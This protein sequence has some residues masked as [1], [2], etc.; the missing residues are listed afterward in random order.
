VETFFDPEATYIWGLAFDGS[1]HLL[2]ATGQPARVHRVAA[3]GSGE[4]LLDSREAHIR[5]LVPDG[6]GGF[7]AGSDG[8]GVI[9]RIAE[10]GEISVLYDTP[11]REISALAV[12]DGH[13]YAAALAPRTKRQQ[14]T[15]S[16]DTRGTVTHVRVTAEGG[17]DQEDEGE[18]QQKGQG[19]R[20]RR[21]PPLET[22]TGAVYRI[23][24]QGYARKIWESTDS[25]P[26]A[27]LPGPG[28]GVLAGTAGGGKILS[29]TPQGDASEIASLESEQV[30]ALLDAGGSGIFAATSNLGAVVR[31]SGSYAREG[32]ILGGVRDAGFT[33]RWGAITWNA[34]VPVGT[35]V[36]FEVRTG[37]TE[38]P[39]S[40]WTDWSGPYREPQ[41]TVIESPPARFLQ[42]RATLTSRDGDVSPVVKAVQIHYLPENMPPEVETVEILDP[43]VWLQSTG[44]PRGGGGN[45]EAR[46]RRSSSPKRALQRGMRTVQWTASDAN[47]DLLTAE[48]RFRA[49]DE[50]VW[51]ILGEDLEESFFAWDSTAMP[52]GVYRLRVVISDAPGNPSGQG[53]STSRD[54]AAFEVDNTPPVVA[55]IVAKRGSRSVVVTATV[56][57]TFSGVGEISYSLDAGDWVIVMP[58][59]GVAD[60]ARETI[61]ITSG[62]LEPGEHSIVIRAR[63]RSGN[64][65]AGKAVVHIP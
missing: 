65:S 51:R 22:Y 60:T 49:E 42:W 31:V 36:R 28:G 30:S 27:L 17:S 62:D 38:D 50:T 6:R 24:E 10:N 8:G 1:G 21:T 23:S 61:R 44:G 14:A 58:E 57:D 37:D 2:V 5:S 40:T 7:L 46:K 9:Y 33:S 56:S 52:D 15:A 20:R 45:G 35:E 29:L 3:D 12:A 13:V 39:D 16:S 32:T 47:K 11:A 54:T 43:G 59:D 55:D 4:I 18:S 41:G 64:V 53:Q 26:L 34:D 25:L 19:S 63:D 48:V